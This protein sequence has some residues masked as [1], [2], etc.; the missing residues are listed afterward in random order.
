MTDVDT[1]L[2]EGAQEQAPPAEIT[3][4]DMISRGKGM[5]STTVNELPADSPVRGAW[6]EFKELVSRQQVAKAESDAL[7]EERNE[8]IYLLKTEHNIGFSAIAEVIGGTSSL[9]LYLFER[10]QGK[11]AKQIRE[12]SIRSREAKEQF[13]ESDPNAK[14]ARKQSPEEKQLRKQQREQLAQFLA[15]ERER[16]AAAGETSEITDEEVVSSEDD[17]T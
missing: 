14:P 8:A 4:E 10:S 16:A 9:V 12:E 3:P 6:D 11:S 15:A 2:E 13:R 17:D 1:T 5:S 7:T